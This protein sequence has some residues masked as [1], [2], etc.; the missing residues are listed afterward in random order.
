EAGVGGAARRRQ[1]TLDLLRAAAVEAGA[2]A[3]AAAEHQDAG[4][5]VAGGA[6]EVDLAFAEVDLEA[7]EAHGRDLRLVDANRH[8][9]LHQ[10][11]RELDRRRP[12]EA[13]RGH[14]WPPR[15]M[16]HLMAGPPMPT[17][18]SCFLPH[19]PLSIQVSVS[20]T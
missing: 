6:Q 20:P 11:G 2:A 19:Q 12:G 14:H 8:R 1:R 10:L 15:V 7:I 3:L 13:L 4:R 18:I 17:G 16:R 5:L 9:A